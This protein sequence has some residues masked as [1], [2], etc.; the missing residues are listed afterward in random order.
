MS[1]LRKRNVSKEVSLKE[2]LKNVF[3]SLKNTYTKLVLIRSK[4]RNRE[5][6]LFEKTVEAKQMNKNEVASVFANEIAEIRKLQRSV[7]ILSL[8][9]EQ[10][11]IRI[12]T[13]IEVGELTY[14]LISSRSLINYVKN[15]IKYVSPE[16][17]QA[18]DELSKN[19]E[20]INITYPEVNILSPTPV[21]EAE[22]VLK[23]AEK[24]VMRRM[25]EKIP[26]IPI[27]VEEK[28]LAKEKI[29][30]VEGYGVEEIPET[31][32]EKIQVIEE[33]Q[34][35]I[36]FE[37]KLLNYIIEN[38]GRINL[39]DCAEKFGVTVEEVNKTLENLTKQGK[40]Q[41]SKR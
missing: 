20:G 10:L 19:I 7:E 37:E 26:E 21:E 27:S 6:D 9:I 23:E 16:L 24:E 22:T 40:I 18:L 11:M 13:I 39:R 12:E 30:E 32:K 28:K 3:L 8:M 17:G 5:R 31:K 25:S 1:F 2:K 29:P 35:A 14:L 4:L 15:D 41:V 38:K 33:K 34:K 36:S